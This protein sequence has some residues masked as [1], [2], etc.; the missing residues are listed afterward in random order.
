MLP[1]IRCLNPANDR[2]VTGIS[3]IRLHT[4]TTIDFDD[5]TYSVVGGVVWTC[6]EESIAIINAN[7]PILRPFMRAIA[8]NF[9]KTGRSRGTADKTEDGTA[10]GKLPLVLVAPR[11]LELNDIGP[12]KASNFSS[13]DLHGSS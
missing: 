8:P 11:Y 2:S 6:L 9:F 4:L 13:S 10:D 5:I 3:V 1:Q 7:L 12:H